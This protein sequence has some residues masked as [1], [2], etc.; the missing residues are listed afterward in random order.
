MRPSSIIWTPGD[1]Q[2][3]WAVM[4]WCDKAYRAGRTTAVLPC[5]DLFRAVMVCLIEAETGLMHALAKV[6]LA[7]PEAVAYP[8]SIGGGQ[9]WCEHPDLK[10]RW[11]DVPALFYGAAQ[12]ASRGIVNATRTP[13][14]ADLSSQDFGGGMGPI[15]VGSEGRGGQSLAPLAAVVL[16]VLGVGAM[17]AG[18]YIAKAGLDSNATVEV[19]KVRIA[20]ELSLKQQ[21]VNAQIA[22]GQMPALDSLTIGLGQKESD[23]GWWIGGVGVALGVGLGAGAYA[24][25]KWR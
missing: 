13:F 4:A 20:A 17:A 12:Y 3:G 2:A 21:A 25:S 23:R 24:G 14:G 15:R 9:Q 1:H 6:G 7:R 5:S 22:A 10:A 8:T 18:A 19:E 16:A 11:Y